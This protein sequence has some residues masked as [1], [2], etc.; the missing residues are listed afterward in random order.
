MGS[1][2][3]EGR[4]RGA[5][6]RRT[7]REMAETAVMKPVRGKGGTERVPMG[8]VPGGSQDALDR[9]GVLAHGIGEVM[10]IKC[11][12]PEGQVRAVLI[13]SA[14][15]IV[16][17]RMGAVGPGDLVA[18]DAFHGREGAVVVIAVG[19]AA[20][21][22]MRESGFFVQPLLYIIHGAGDIILPDVKH[23]FILLSLWGIAASI[24]GALPGKCPC[25]AGYL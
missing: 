2:S 3:R 21:A 18:A 13:G 4:L 19:H 1:S 8:A 15:A 24:G 17:L 22:V 25:C 6:V 20:A 23:C 10:Q 9:A 5:P 16:Q 14:Y 7:K 11:A 12:I